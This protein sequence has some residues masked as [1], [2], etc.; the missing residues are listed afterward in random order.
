MIL[1]KYVVT[2]ATRKRNSHESFSL[3]RR[4][5][6]DEVCLHYLKIFHSKHMV[7]TDDAHTVDT[8]LVRFFLR[9]GCRH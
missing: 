3:E 9:L 4:I 7:E 6:F 8:S 5:Y 2:I 1:I